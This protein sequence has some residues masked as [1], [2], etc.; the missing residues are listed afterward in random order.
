VTSVL[1]DER[2]PAQILVVRAEAGTEVTSAVLGCL[3]GIRLGQVAT[4]DP[5]LE[6]ACVELVSSGA[7]E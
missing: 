6:D 5:T 4:R 7:P 1:V 3:N 2:G